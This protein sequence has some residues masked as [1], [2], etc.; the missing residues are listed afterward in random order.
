M[1]RI[2]TKSVDIESKTVTFSFLN[3]DELIC[4]LADLPDE[5]QNKLMLHGLSQKVG[6]S[7]AQAENIEAGFISATDVYTNLV[8]NS[9]STKTSRG[10]KIVEALAAFS[11]KPMAE[12][13]E[14]YSK[15]DDK[16]KA[17]L[18]KHPSIKLELATI[19]AKRAK[20]AAESV[21]EADASD[22][23]GLFN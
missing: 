4:R 8:N 17:V 22:L 21:T 13:L 6:D 2:A 3:E 7:Y 9:W 18:R 5:I 20:A 11:G 19:E 15:M 10:G 23:E 14:V 16:A 1:A 12:C